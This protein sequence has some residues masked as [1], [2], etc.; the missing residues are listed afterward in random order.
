MAS[1]VEISYTSNQTY[2]SLLINLTF[3]KTFVFEILVPKSLSRNVLINYI[4]SPEVTFLTSIV[5]RFNPRVTKLIFWFLGH[6][7]VEPSTNQTYGSLLSNLT[8]IK[9]FAY[10]ILVP[11]SYVLPVDNSHYLQPYTSLVLDAHKEGL[12]IFASEFANDYISFIDNDVFSMDG[13][14]SDLPVTAS[15]IIGDA[16]LVIVR[17]GFSGLFLDS[18]YEAYIMAILETSLP[19]VIIWCD[20]QLTKNEVDMCF[21]DLKLDNTSDIDAYYK[22][23]R[24]KYLMNIVLTQGWF[25]I[26]FD[27]NDHMPVNFFTQ[28]NLSMR[29][30]IIFIS[31]NVL[32]NYISSPEDDVESSINQTYG[33]L[34]NNLTFIKTFASG[35]LVPKSCIWLVDNSHY[36]QPYTSLVLDA[37]KECLEIFASDYD[38]TSEYFSLIDNDVFSVDGVLYDFPVTASATIVVHSGELLDCDSDDL[39]KLLLPPSSSLAASGNVESLVSLMLGDA[40]LV[41]A[42]G[43]V[44]GLFPDSS[45]EAYT[46]AMETSLPNVISWCDVQLTKDGVG[47]CFPDLK[48][49]NASDIDVHYKNNKSEYLVNR[50]LMQGWF[51]VDFNFN[52]LAPVTCKDVAKQVKPP[53]L[54]LNIQHDNFFTQ[55]NLSMR[56]YIISLSK[57]VLI[58]YISPLASKYFKDHF[59]SKISRFGYR[60]PII[61][62]RIILG[63]ERLKSNTD[64]RMDGYETQLRL[65]PASD[66]DADGI[67][68][69][70]SVGNGYVPSHPD[71]GCDTSLPNVISWCDVQLTKDG[72]ACNA[73]DIDVHYKNNKSEY[74]VNRV[75]IQGWFS[76]DFN[77]NDLAP[78]TLRQGVYIRTE[79]FD[80]TKYRILTVQDVANQVKPPGLWLNIQYDNFFTQHNL[81]MRSYIISLSKNVLI[82]YISSPEVTFLTSI[83]ARFNPRVTKLVFQFLGQD[84]EPSINQTYGFLLNNL[85]FIKPFASG[86]LVPK[87]YIWPMDNSHYLQPYTSLVLDAHKEGL[88]IFASEFAN[89]VHFPYNF[90]YDPTSE[91]LS[92]IDNGV[93]SVDGVLSDVP[94][95]ASAT[96]DCFA[97]LNKNDKPREKFLIITS[98]GASGD[99]PGCTD[100]AYTKAVSDGADVLDC[101]VQMTKDGIPF[102]LGSINLVDKTTI[103]QSPFSNIT[104]TDAVLNIITGIFTFNLNWDEIKSLK[105]MSFLEGNVVLNMLSLLV[106]AISSPWSGFGLYRNPKAINDGSFVSLVDFLIY[107][108][109]ATT[110]SGVMIRIEKADYLANQGFGVIAAVVEALRNTGYNNQTS[111][112]VMIQSKDSSVLKEFKKRSYELV[113][114]IDDNI[115]DIESATI[116]EIK[117]FASSVI[118]TKNSVFRSEDDFLVGKTDVVQKLQS[119]NLSFVSQAWDF[120]SDSSV[121]INNYV[122][123]AGIDGVITDF[124]RTAATY[125]RNRCLGYKHRSLYFSPVETGGLLQFMSRQSLPPAEPPSPIL[126]ESDVVEP[127]LPPVAKI[128]PASNADASPIAQSSVVAGVLTCCLTILLADLS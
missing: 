120:F 3:I 17:G 84:V 61:V 81:S 29:S 109:S 116:S 27:F 25:T 95:T 52:D 13:V 46:M 16:P 20:V 19:N 112:K 104:N 48:L 76:V 77:F 119:S 24:S 113:Y 90:S 63:K 12:E 33:S 18:S 2:G 88:E 23:N 54:W 91:Y 72:V 8:F 1:L 94:V 123:G 98:E 44:S 87:S 62:I 45:Y 42:R 73:S 78:V 35:I 93:F 10:G 39:L 106:A 108:K 100:M 121:E 57:N 66:L 70:C 47:I 11:K 126:T 117:S 55:H 105:L 65:A 107:A 102:C 86:I 5:A 6:D 80:G 34:L 38:P 15:A 21:A 118:L 125:R 36:L 122:V 103:L 89:D 64:M 49:D 111:K 50:V 28:H 99:Y 37:H 26:D 97:H 67:W 124:P 53:G 32:I 30:Y 92:F 79:K 128:T 9:T 22:N 82:N 74:L 14:L 71:L 59:T 40:P 83:V 41:I 110:L 58:N 56:S 31:R 51:S 7:D 68:L 69:T 75:L 4:S 127:P 43:G 60:F 114:M 115:R 96:I 85:T 101:P